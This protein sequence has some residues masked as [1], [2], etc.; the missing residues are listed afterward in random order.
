MSSSKIIDLS[1]RIRE[2]MMVYPGLPH[3]DFQ[4][5]EVPG[6]EGNYTSQITLAAHVGTHIDSPKH[7]VSSGKSLNELSL[8]RFVGEALLLDIDTEHGSR[9]EL[10]DLRNALDE[11]N[12]KIRE[13]DIL[14]LNT[15]IYHHFG[16]PAFARQYPVPTEETFRYVLDRGIRCYGTDASS[17]DLFG[18]E[19]SPNHQIVLG[20]GVPIVENLTNLDQIGSQRF[21]FMALPLRIERAEGSPCRAIGLL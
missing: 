10:D 3:P 6:V 17:I 5:L 4:W 9:V 19:E 8:D 2:E 15:G 11:A 13:G 1:Y 16:E 14:I 12:E 7:F 20:A 18:S 21:Q